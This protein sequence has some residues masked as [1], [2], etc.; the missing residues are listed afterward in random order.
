MKKLTKAEYQRKFEMRT[1]LKVKQGR[2]RESRLGK[3]CR[4]MASADIV[5]RRSGWEA[6]CAFLVHKR[7]EKQS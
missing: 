1:L 7:K 3:K 6:A 5:E 2:L 4:R